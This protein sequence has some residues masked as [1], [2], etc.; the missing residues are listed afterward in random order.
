MIS[1]GSEVKLFEKGRGRHVVIHW[2]GEG[3]QR[4][5]ALKHQMGQASLEFLLQKSNAG[6][7]QS[8]AEPRVH[9]FPEGRGK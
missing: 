5:L 7:A 3:G 1:F 6:L 4:P 8:P 9:T 2:V